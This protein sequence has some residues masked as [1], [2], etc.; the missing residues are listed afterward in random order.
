[1]SLFY[2]RPRRMVAKSQQ[3]YQGAHVPK[4]IVT[5]GSR[6]AGPSGALKSLTAGVLKGPDRG[7]GA[8]GR[9]IRKGSR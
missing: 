5:G 9:G 3:T 8:S 6:V 4:R 2:E 1:M 7:I